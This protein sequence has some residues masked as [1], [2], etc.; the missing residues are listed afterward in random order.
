M[1]KE[2][3]RSGFIAIIGR[4]N[5]GKS[6]LLNE[7][8]GRKVAIM[9]DKPQ[10]TRNRIT[11]VLTQKD[12][13]MIFIDTPGIHK[14]KHK[15]GKYMVDVA[16]GSLEGVDLVYYMVDANAS[17]GSGEQYVVNR[18]KNSKIP[19]FLILNKIDLLTP[20]KI[21][22]TISEWQSRADF[23]EVFPLSALKGD[24]VQELVAKTIEYLPEGP[25]FYPEDAVT[26]QPEQVV[27]GELIRE[28]VLHLTREE[29]PHSVAVVVEM[30]ETR[31][32]NTV[33]IGATIYVER[34]SQKGIVIGKKGAL[35]KEIG[36][37]ARMDIEKLLG[38]K[39]FL[40]LWVK[41]KDDWR[42]RERILRD[43]GYDNRL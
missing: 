43:L 32:K 6:T 20:D 5:A 12:A 27:I 38:S 39:V 8:L 29:I 9:S 18:L 2:D 25:Q 1:N 15:L 41:V 22:Q 26:D 31:P 33:Y 24:N 40:D 42:N 28:K 13:Q 3:Y 7:I 34:D 19:V 30:L 16:E 36:L 4:P 21:L 37:Q 10:T 35:L 23:A 14:P 11:G 17:F